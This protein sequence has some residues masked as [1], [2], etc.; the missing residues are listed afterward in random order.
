MD[1]VRELTQMIFWIAI[2][3]IVFEYIKFL[4]ENTDDDF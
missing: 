2:L 4:F 3:L 1:F